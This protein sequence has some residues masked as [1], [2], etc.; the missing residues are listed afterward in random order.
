MRK[1]L[2]AAILGLVLLLLL[3]TARP[4]AATHGDLSGLYGGNLCGSVRN[5]WNPQPLTATDPDRQKT[6]STTYNNLPRLH[7]FNPNLPPYAAGAWCMYRSHHPVPLF[8]G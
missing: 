2:V 4:A 3:S 1:I 5:A 7:P 6:T 8:A